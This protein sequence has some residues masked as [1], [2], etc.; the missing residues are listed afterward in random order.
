MGFFC[1]FKKKRLSIDIDID[2][3]VNK[4]GYTND[5]NK[6]INKKTKHSPNL[7]IT[8]KDEQ[9][10]YLKYLKDDEVDYVNLKNYET[11]AKCLRIVD[12]DTCVVAFFKNGELHK[13]KCRL[14]GIDTAEINSDSP[15]EKFV[16]ELAIKRVQDFMG[17]KM[18]IYIRCHNWDKYGRLLIDIYKNDKKKLLLN[19]ILIKDGLAYEYKGN[20]KR[21]FNDWYVKK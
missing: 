1:C 7:I 4:A 5:I 16:G 2:N 17:K 8:D 11:Y 20:K 15:E 19:H 12:G 13:Y 21:D 10:K 6:N 9:F 18:M 3:I 14:S